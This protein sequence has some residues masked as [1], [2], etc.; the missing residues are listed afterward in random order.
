MT[1]EEAIA[2]IH[3]V[4]WRGSRLGLT[5]IRE[6]LERLGNPQEKLKFVHIA[7]T[8]G[9][10]SVAAM[11][12]SILRQAGYRTGLFTSPYI[13]RFNER[14]MVDGQAIGDEE[15]A[16]LVEEIR[17]VAESME[18]KPTEFEM[19]TALGMVY[20]QRSGCDIVVLETGLGGELDSTN[21]IPVPEVAVITS[22]GYDHMEQLG[23]TITK[24]AAAK[25]G[26]IKEGGL[27]A[28][29]GRNPEAEEVIRRVCEEKHARVVF[30]D[31]GRPNPVL[32]D[33]NGTLFDMGGLQNLRIP[34][35]GHYQLYNAALAVLT[36]RLLN[37]KGFYISDRALR[38]GLAQT[39]WRGR[40]EM[41]SEYPRVIVDGSHN[42]PGVAATA[43]SL[44]EYFPGEKIIFLM[45][46]MADK[47]VASMI[48][49]LAPLATEF[50]TIAPDY[51]R[52]LAADQLAE[53][54]K[55]LTGKPATAAKDIPEGCALAMEKAGYRGV[56]CAIGSLYGVGDVTRE[57]KKLLG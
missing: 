49:A 16:G 35:L 42:P 20:F 1:Y 47:D 53:K 31:Y 57:L 6:L 10:G 54:I 3:K 40:L 34:L 29:Y 39:K 22:I 48:G 37:E 41:I 36:T 2:Y 30:I 21:V 4:S 51:P 28:C 15:L 56:V 32:Q 43:E 27:V 38:D 5:R 55:T 52:A 25:A 19:I 13:F 11:L 18:D 17:P 26:I 8:N 9:K 24:I 46:V 44:A 50:V 45:G 33:T 23:D 14:I 12:D 7:G